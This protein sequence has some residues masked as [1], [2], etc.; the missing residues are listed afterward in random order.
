MSAAGSKRAIVAALLANLG[1]AI[2]KFVGF[3]F[4]G[5]SSMLAESIHSV[6]DTGNQV[7]LLVGGRRAERVATRQH[8]FGFGRERFFWAFVVAIVL[9]TLGSA[10]ALFEGIEKLLHPHQLES[11]G[12]AIAILLIAMALEGFSFRTA[13]K[14]SRPLK[15]NS[16]WFQFIRRSKQPE[17]PVVLL[18]DSGALVGL[19]IALFAVSMAAITGNGRW[20][21]VGTTAIGLLLGVIA[22][23]LAVEMKSLLI[24]ESASE[25]DE[26]AIIA[27]INGAE[28][29][30]VLIDLRTEHIGPESIL[31]AAKI[32][33]DQ[34]LTMRQLADVV[35]AVEAD[36]RAAVPTV[37]R[38]FLEPD[39][40]RPMTAT[41]VEPTADPHH[42]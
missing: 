25:E 18:E 34:D 11:A 24:G 12:W 8:P 26:A 41:V 5:S 32:E 38:I 31:V 23:V 20:D 27:A 30:R 9:F 2:A 4:T 40:V 17:L 22:I 39:I 29:V 10:F 33:F 1:I 3:A 42:R 19:V 37:T 35:D 15:G 7:L 13:V 36:I 16:S 21:G 28:A 6:A 14:E